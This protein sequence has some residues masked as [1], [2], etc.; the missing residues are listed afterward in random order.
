LKKI[1]LPKYIFVHQ[2]YDQEPPPVHLPAYTKAAK[3]RR[4]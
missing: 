4:H 2:S 1:K 3:S